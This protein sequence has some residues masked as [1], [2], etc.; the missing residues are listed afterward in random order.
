MFTECVL[1]I[2]L[3]AQVKGLDTE[4]ELRER[5]FLR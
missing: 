4:I 5:E 2:N 3:R 1:I